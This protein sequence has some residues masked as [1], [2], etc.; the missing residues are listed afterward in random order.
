M[1]TSGL[2]NG[3]TGPQSRMNAITTYNGSTADPTLYD[4]AKSL[5]NRKLYIAAG[6]I[7]GIIFAIVFVIF[8][9]SLY[10]AIMVIAPVQTVVSTVPIQQENFYDATR[11]ETETAEANFVQFQTMMKG[12][13]IAK[14]VLKDPNIIKNLKR[15]PKIK[16]IIKDK[17]TPALVAEYLSE[18]LRIY[19]VGET[20]LRRMEYTHPDPAFT[21]YFLNALYTKTDNRIRSIMARRTQNY[22]AYLQDLIANTIN[23]EHRRKLTDMLMEQE[24][25]RMLVSVQNEYAASIVEPAYAYTKPVWP[26]KLLILSAFIIL[27]AIA[28][29]LISFVR[30]AR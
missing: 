28:G 18:N 15:D 23:P 21:I 25:A 6:A 12:A 14:E 17:I 2:A 27:G 29:Y 10:K 26:D 1:G 20:D 8:S 24:R 3:G 5:W 7:T 19:T 13:A 22:I 4:V 30:D 11:K 16:A 9:T